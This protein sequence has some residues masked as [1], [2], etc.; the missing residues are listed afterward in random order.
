MLCNLL[1]RNR[2][3]TLVGHIYLKVTSHNFSK[4][5]ASELEAE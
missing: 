3:F 5:M 1:N 2:P 4:K